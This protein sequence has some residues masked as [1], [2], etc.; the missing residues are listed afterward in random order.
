MTNTGDLI[1]SETI[2]AR[3][4]LIRGEMVL[5]SSHLADWSITIT[6]GTLYLT[7]NDV[8]YETAIHIKTGTL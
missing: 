6:E 5:L 7:T 1:S 2:G 8:T 3:I 4:L